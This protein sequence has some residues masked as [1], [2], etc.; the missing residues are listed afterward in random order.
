MKKRLDEVLISRGDVKDKNDA[1]LIVTEGK[2]FVDGQKMISPAQMIKPDA[3]IKIRSEQEYVG[4]GALKLAA[5]LDN[6]DIDVSGKVCADIGAAT[7]GFTEILLRNGAKKV[8]AI[9]T[10]RGK[11]ALKIR[12]NPR[13]VVMEKIDVRTLKRLPEAV[14]FVTID[15]SLISLQEILQAAKRFLK[16]E[17]SVVALFKPQYESRDPKILKHG[18][19]RDERNRQNLLKDFMLWAENNG[20]KIKS[21]MK[22]PIRGGKG[23]V[24]FLLYL[25]FKNLKCLL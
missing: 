4:R 1:F 21:H 24:E 13:V 10:A 14:D 16:S 15:V 2:V 22:S 12:K 25:K 23:N 8:Y 6:F 18:I 5:A 3:E 7:G 9:D 17:G 19:V 11:L 20:W